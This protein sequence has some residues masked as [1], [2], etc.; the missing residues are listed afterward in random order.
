MTEL[1]F[2][3]SQLAS[4]GATAP[5]SRVEVFDGVIANIS[6]ELGSAADDGSDGVTV[7]PGFVDIH[8]HGAFGVDVNSAKTDDLLYLAG[9]LA[10]HGVAGWMPTLV[11]DAEENYKKAIA[12]IDRLI[13]IQEGRPVAQAL[14]VH[15]EGVFAA[16]KMCG[17]LR[18]EFFKKY[19]PGIVDTLPRLKRGIHMT[20]L[21]PE[22]EGGIYLI[23]EFREADFVVSI[24]HTRAD[25]QTLDLAFDAGARHATHFFNAMTG[26]HHRDLGVAGWCLTKPEMTFD[27]IADGIHVDEQMLT[28]AV[29]AR[30][31]DG[32]SLISDSISATGQGDGSFQ[33]WEQTITV[34]NGRT[35]NASGGIAGSVITMADAVKRVLKL[36]FSSQAVAQMSS[37]NPARLLGFEKVF[38]SVAPR[39]RADLAGLNADGDIVFSMI[40]GE[41]IK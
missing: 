1:N 9:K 15:Y 7:L 5:L 20:T 2:T 17:A 3:N 40:G 21:A 14:G 22:I 38:G 34:E 29:N 35:R 4:G 32:V 30:G 37:A 16:E 10:E 36:G 25:R 8:N 39:R 31:T 26:I 41:R 27:I 19:K 24:G 11:P 28:L 6:T 23:R 12:A 13:E 33:L 18:T